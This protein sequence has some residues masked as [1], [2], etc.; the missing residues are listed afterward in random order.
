MQQELKSYPDHKRTIRIKHGERHLWKLFHPYHYMTSELHEDKSLASG[1][2]F[3]TFYLVKDNIETLFGCVGVI[4]QISKIP[5]RRFTR[6]VILPEFQGLGLVGPCIDHLSE[7]YH[8]KGIKI[9]SATFHPK[10]GHYREKSDLWMPSANNMKAHK[11]SEQNF[12]KETGRGLG[13]QTGLRDGQAMFRYNYN[14]PED[15]ACPE[16]TL[17]YDLLEI[18]ALKT[19]R[20]RS[21]DKNERSILTQSIND[22]EET[23]KLQ[24]SI[25]EGKDL[26]VMSNDEAEDAK[27]TL[28]RALKKSKRKKTTPE[29]LQKL[30]E[31]KEKNA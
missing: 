10:L 30:K 19:K 28:G 1:A 29:Q 5:A 8:Q 23:M 12:N 16:F 11:I 7:Y 26:A 13:A 25:I 9:Y 31:L 17:V 21:K 20:Q 24:Q 3:F 4:P 22:L 14:P 15:V 27:K 18:L 2:S 6:L